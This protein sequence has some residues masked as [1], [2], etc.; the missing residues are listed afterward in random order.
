MSH[1]LK[2]SFLALVVF[3]NIGASLASDAKLSESSRN[4][5]VKLAQDVTICLDQC[6]STFNFCTAGQP[7]CGNQLRACQASCRAH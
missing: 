6:L 2:I 7:T 1:V 5:R 3:S 4:K